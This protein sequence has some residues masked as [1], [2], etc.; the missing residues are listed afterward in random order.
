[1]SRPVGNVESGWLVLSVVQGGWQQH[2]V[3]C[4]L[5]SDAV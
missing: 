5:V 3:I 1:M 2:A 4:A